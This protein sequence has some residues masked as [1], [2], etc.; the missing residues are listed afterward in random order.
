MPGKKL[1]ENAQISGWRAFWS[2]NLEMCLFILQ[3]RICCGVNRQ[4]APHLAII[5]LQNENSRRFKRHYSG[6]P[7]NGYAC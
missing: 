4:P 6:N 1:K 3:F 5:I 2:L 7:W